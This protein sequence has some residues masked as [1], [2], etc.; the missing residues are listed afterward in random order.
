MNTEGNGQSVLSTLPKELPLDFLRTITN[1]FSE[2]RVLGTG[3]FGTV[4]TGIM[5][6]GQHIAVKRLAENAPLPRDKAI[7]NEVQ[8][9]MALK[10][11]NIVKLV[12]FCHE[13]QKRVVL[14]NGRYI[15]ADV[16]ESLLCYEYLP[17][18]SLLKNLFDRSNSMAWDTRFKIIKGICNGLLFLHRIPIIHMDLKPE[19]ILLDDNMNP[20]IADFGLSRLFGQEQ[21]RANTQNVVGSYGY[22]APEYLYRGEISAQSDIYSLGLLIIETTTG[23]KNQ[24]KQNEPSARDFIENVRQNWTDGRI[25]SRYSTLKA[26]DLQEIKVCIKI[27]LE[28]VQID[29]KKRPSIENIV[30]RLDGRCAN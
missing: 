10:H 7:T 2:D 16:F 8:N 4:Y 24:P 26:N 14:N 29:R 30:Q 13:G 21:T 3:T 27:G 9:I 18:G 28:C 6:D 17:K 11:D 23:E 20:K 1:Q 12:G 5:P 25:A 22:I 15:V 19:N